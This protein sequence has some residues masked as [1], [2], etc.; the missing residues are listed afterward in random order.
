[1]K[2]RTWTGH[3]FIATSIDGFISEPDG[4]LDWLTD[5]PPETRHAAA[6][7]GQ[8]APPG[9]E[10]F[11]TAMSHLVM[12]RGTYEKVLTFNRWPYDRLEVL[13]ISTT[14]PQASDD[15]VTVLR[16]LADACSRLETDRATAV[17][18]D[19]GQIVSQF[20]AAGLIDELTIARAPVI[21]GDGLPLFHALPHPIR[22]LHE[23]T[24]TTN[25]GMTN[26]RYRVD[27]PT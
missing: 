20:L 9:Y 7:Q 19:G 23:G 18:V 14:L 15:R 1:M 26:T 24:S 10:E 4:G 13:V 8:D 22:L 12:G 11:T 27:R 2:L 17:Y 21:L 3:V 16:S 5:P 25:T 6:H